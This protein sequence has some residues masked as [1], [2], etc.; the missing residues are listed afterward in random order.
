MAG[1]RTVREL[2]KKAGVSRNSVW[3]WLAEQG[4]DRTPTGRWALTEEQAQ[5]VLER[6]EHTAPLR[7]VRQPEPCSVEDCDR[8]RVGLQDVCKLHYQR[9]ARTGRL[10]R[11]T[12]GEWQAAK[13]HCPQ[14]HEYTPENTYT[15]PSDRG[16]KRRCRLCRISQSEATRRRPRPDSI[17]T[18][19]ATP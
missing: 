4:W 12:G 13:T 3:A 6:F 7:E 8:D 14:G 1:E 10:E 16:T 11:S 18:L 15:F 5:L 19:D 17:F 2:A 9:R